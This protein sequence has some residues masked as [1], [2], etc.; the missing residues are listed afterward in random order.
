MAR[1]PVDDRPTDGIEPPSMLLFA[2]EGQRALLEAA[3]LIP[4]KKL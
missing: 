4:A 2:L 3:S 1:P